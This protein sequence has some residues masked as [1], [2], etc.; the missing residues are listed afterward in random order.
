MDLWIIHMVMD[1]DSQYTEHIS[2]SCSF[3]TVIVISAPLLFE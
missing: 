2:V 1:M 3:C